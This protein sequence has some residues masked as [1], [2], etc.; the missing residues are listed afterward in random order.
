MRRNRSAIHL[1]AREA[2]L[3]SQKSGESFALRIADQVLVSA[4]GGC[5]QNLYQRRAPSSAA[6]FFGGDS[7]LGS[8]QQ[9]VARIAMLLG[10]GNIFVVGNSRLRYLDTP[11]HTITA[12]DH[13]PVVRT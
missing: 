5:L 2:L 9:C 8:S 1:D 3:K 13:D 4:A 10:R 11:R 6:I 7:D 12:I